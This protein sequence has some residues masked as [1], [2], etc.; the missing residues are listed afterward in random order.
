MATLQRAGLV[1]CQ[2]VGQFSHYSRNEETIA[3]LGKKVSLAI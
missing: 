1:T 3:A 2:R